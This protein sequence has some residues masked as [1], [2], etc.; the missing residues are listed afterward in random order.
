MEI[1]GDTLSDIAFEKSG[2]F[3][4]GSVA[5][6]VPQHQDA[7][8]KVVERA[9]ALETDLFLTRPLAELL[10]AEALAS[11]TA[12]FQRVNASLALALSTIWMAKFSK[13]PFAIP[14][15]AVAIGSAPDAFPVFETSPSTV[16]GI[17]NF[18]WPG[19]AQIVDFSDRVRLFLDGAHTTESIRTCLEWYLSQTSTFLSVE[20]RWFAGTGSL[21]LFSGEPQ[22]ARIGVLVFHCN[23]PRVPKHLLAPIAQAI[24]SGRLSVSKLWITVPQVRS[25]HKDDSNK[26]AES[27]YVDTTWQELIEKDWKELTSHLSPQGSWPAVEIVRSVDAALDAVSSSASQE[28]SKSGVNALIFGSLYLVGAA[29][30]ALEGRAI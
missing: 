9:K 13:T 22:S 28:T 17:L 18:N 23:K 15:P 21:S 26:L 11:M 10:P 30:E 16:N 2:I 27:K 7:M 12:D 19:R 1:L 24:V 20:H 4:P 14:R 5:V 25:A 6:T 3:K 29:L 8:S